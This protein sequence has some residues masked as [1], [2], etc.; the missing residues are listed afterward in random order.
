VSVTSAELFARQAAPMPPEGAA[1][2][3]AWYAVYTKPRREAQAQWHLERKGVEVFFPKLQLPPYAA[4]RQT[5]VPLFPGYI[6]VHVALPHGFYDVI[7]APGVSRFVGFNDGIAPL[8]DDVVAFMKAH[9]NDDGVLVARSNLRVGQEVE[10][11]GGPFAGVAG[12]IQ[13]PPD[14]KGRIK[15]LMQLLSR[16]AVMVDVPVRYVKAHWSV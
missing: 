7:W 13:R 11:T 2:G 9:A 16:R 4:G 10:I 5:V 14:A 3:Q 12:L 8:G 6:F 15:I 1:R